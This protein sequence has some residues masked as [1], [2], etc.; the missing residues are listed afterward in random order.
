[1]S[2]PGPLRTIGVL[3]GIGLIGGR[4][5]QRLLR[6]LKRIAGWVALL[7]VPAA[8]FV[9]LAITDPQ[10]SALAVVG[11]LGLGFA[12]LL[13]WCYIAFAIWLTHPENDAADA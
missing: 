8:V 4:R 1:M 10:A 2:E 5:G 6:A 11:F 9:A 3:V 7:S 12:A 13:F